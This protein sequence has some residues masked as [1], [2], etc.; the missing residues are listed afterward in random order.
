VIITGM[1]RSGT[2]FT[3]NLLQKAGV[4]IGTDLLGA[5]K[6]NPRGHF[7]DVEFLDFHETLLRRR[8]LSFFVESAEKLGTVT[9]LETSR[10]Q[11]LIDQR[12][13]RGLWGWKEPRTTLFLDLWDSLLPGACF[14]FVYRHPIDVVL[15][16]LRRATDS[17]ALASPFLALRVWY[18]YNQAMIEFARKHPGRCL[19]CHVV[20]LA[21][22]IPDFKSLIAERFGLDLN[23]D[24]TSNIYSPD[25]LQQNPFASDPRVQ[26]ALE[27]VAPEVPRLLAELES[28]ADLPSNTADKA[29]DPS[30]S[31]LP[32]FLH[33]VGKAFRDD[34]SEASIRSPLFSLLLSLF[35]PEVMAGLPE[36]AL[37]TIETLFQDRADY[38]DQ[39]RGMSQNLA[40]TKEHTDRLTEG[41][42]KLETDLTE[43]NNQVQSL[44]AMQKE[45]QRESATRFNSLNTELQEEKQ[46][47][48]TLQAAAVE[49]E[50][51]RAETEILGKQL[52]E[53]NHRIQGLEDELQTK[54]TQIA[55]QEER[56]SNQE[57]RLS[58]QADTLI[59]IH[60]SRSWRL[61]ESYW[62][63]KKRILRFF[64]HR[65]R[66]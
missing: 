14:V 13:A 20:A 25:L 3:A 54:R 41:N 44:Q 43:S 40:E 27:M 10:A 37:K 32:E 48:E 2:S 61:V 16:L 33:L 60:G 1:H 30:P 17:Q 46:R 29:L 4:N 11:A 24:E 47:T 23:F 59:A 62:N 35:A 38:A 28:A 64:G 21:E 26:S 8:G 49:L 52:Q 19:L 36:T 18:V 51:K 15:S 7:E 56:L 55:Q 66:S 9:A 63:A 50:R 45:Q 5:W 12:Q 22:G 34:R 65:K 58:T 42:A 6:G 39:H 31:L 53:N 57:K